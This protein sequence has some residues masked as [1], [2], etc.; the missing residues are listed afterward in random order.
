MTPFNPHAARSRWF[1]G[2]PPAD[3]T[4]REAALR[5]D[6]LAAVE[7]A[8]GLEQVGWLYQT[9]AARFPFLRRVGDE[10]NDSGEP[11]YVVREAR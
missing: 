3:E 7:W 5:R 9:D 2:P 10:W 8:E 11:V 4:P 1:G 6:L